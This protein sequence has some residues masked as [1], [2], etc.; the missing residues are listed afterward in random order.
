MRRY[1]FGVTLYVMLLGEDCADLEHGDGQ[2]DY[3]WHPQ[4]LLPRLQSL[5][6]LELRWILPRR[7]N[8]LPIAL[9]DRS[10]AV[11]QTENQVASWR[12]AVVSRVRSL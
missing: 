10:W 7:L 11:S 2:G 8:L 3:L 1:S 6:P 9:L 4:I 5:L 12:Q